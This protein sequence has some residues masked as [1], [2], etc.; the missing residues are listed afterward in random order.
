MPGPGFQH[1]PVLSTNHGLLCRLLS[2]LLLREL[3]LWLEGN[4]A[5]GSLAYPIGKGWLYAILLGIS[6]YFSTLTHHQVFW[7]ASPLLQ[8]AHCTVIRTDQHTLL[9]VGTLVPAISVGSLM[10][11][12]PCEQLADRCS[13]TIIR[14]MENY[15]FE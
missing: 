2:P 11:V 6:G 10:L 13:H 9:A 14:L 15:A 5:F 12:D 8:C 1:E 7:S 4:K 3:L